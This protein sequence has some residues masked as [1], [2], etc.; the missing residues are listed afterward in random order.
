MQFRK[1]RGFRAFR[2]RPVYFDLS[3]NIE[4]VVHDIRAVL[5]VYSNAASARDISDNVIPGNGLAAMS[6]SDHHIGLSA[7]GYAALGILKLITLNLFLLLDLDLMRIFML[8][9]ES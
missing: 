3:G 8:N 2:T 9:D 1:E 4:G 7:D 6:E 5:T